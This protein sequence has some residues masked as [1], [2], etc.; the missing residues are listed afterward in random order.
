MDT[1]AL[2]F[3]IKRDCSEDGPGIRT[4]VFFKGCPLSCDWCQNPE[5]QVNRPQLSFDEK[6]CHAANCK[7]EC[8]QA[9]PTECLSKQSSNCTKLK[10]DH[11]FC[12]SGDSFCTRCSDACQYNALKSSGYW[13]T[14]EELLYRVTIDEPFYKST[15]GGVTLSGGEATMQFK[16]VHQ[17]LRALKKRGIHTTIETCGFFNYRRFR[18]LILPYVDLIYFDFKLMDDNLSWQH[19]G[20]SNK[21]I[22][23]NFKR[24]VA[25]AKTSIIPRIPLIPGITATRENLQNIAKFLS[26]CA[27]QNATL[28]PYNPLWRDKLDKFNLNPKYKRRS[29]MTKDELQASV[30]HFKSYN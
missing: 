20:Q 14:Q 15:G 16:F 9:C 25:D 1:K 12:I 19:T 23:K 10:I 29:F 11:Q 28:L 21:L 4:T 7:M 2:I 5:G 18:E 24:L 30:A 8:V 17:F 13:I 26:E 6:L 3:D 27:V 22:L